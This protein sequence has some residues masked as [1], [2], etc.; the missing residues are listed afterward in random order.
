MPLLFQLQ[1]AS[2]GRFKFYADIF[3]D[4]ENN[5]KYLVNFLLLRL[6]FIRVHTTGEE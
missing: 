2:P 5:L 1:I 6:G 4:H 3:S